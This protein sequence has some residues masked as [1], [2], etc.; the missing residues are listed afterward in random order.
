MILH[1]Q[2]ADS[3]IRKNQS[4]IRTGDIHL[5]PHTYPNTILDPDPDFAIP[6]TQRL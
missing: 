4:R 3:D 1:F 6:V 5:D 2:Y